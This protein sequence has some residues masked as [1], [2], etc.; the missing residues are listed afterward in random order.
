MAEAKLQVSG[1]VAIDSPAGPSELL[2]ICDAGADPDLIARELVAQAEHDPDTFVLALAVGADLANAIA[3]SLV[4]AIDS[5]PRRAI[6]AAALGAR[7]GILEADDVAQAIALANEIA[8][9][10][11][12]VVCADSAAVLR[13]LR[14]AGTV[15]IGATSSV[16]FGD[17]L[18]G[19]NHVLPTGGLARCYSG[20]STLDFVRW[21]TYQRIDRAA[22]ARLASD[23]AIFAAAEGLPGHA[24]AASAWSTT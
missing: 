6:V 5:A 14:G 9:E 15:F 10:H 2:I 13:E 16:A 7:G 22:A 12:L 21:T 8:A 3:A 20:L 4:G 23:V 24:A 19:A 11:V 17:Y 18:T 1:S